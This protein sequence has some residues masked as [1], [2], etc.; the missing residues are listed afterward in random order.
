M[1]YLMIILIAALFLSVP[2]EADEE[3]LCKIDNMCKVV[4]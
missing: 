3:E 1:K 2:V 4:V